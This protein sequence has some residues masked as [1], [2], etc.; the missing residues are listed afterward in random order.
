MSNVETTS[1]DT[2]IKG[3]IA[4]TYTQMS[5]A[6]RKISDY[7]LTNV[8]RAATMSIDELAQTI[9]VSIATANRYARALGFEGYPQFRSELVKGFEAS[10]APIDNLRS[11]LEQAGSVA[12]IITNSLRHDVA[13]LEATSLAISP[14]IYERA[15]DMILA[16]ER[17]YIVGYGASAFLSGLMAS[18]L[19]P[20]CATIQCTIGS[21]G[22]VQVGRQLFKYT[23]K[24]LVIG[25]SFPRYAKDIVTQLTQVKEQGVPILIITDSP[26]SPLAAFG[27]INLYVETRRQFLP[28]SE[29]AALCLIEA[30]CSAV[31]SKS[32][33]PISGATELSKFMLPWIYQSSNH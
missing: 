14:E 15:V 3:R 12:D 16:A 13:N 10:M 8:F 25:I 26:T 2:S 20:F 4:K 29:G 33:S 30:L 7:I 27:S 1:I 31:A 11:E 24:D 22:S 5:K 21:S 6:H 18:A 19:E 17:I 23:K 28:N 32:D 9:G